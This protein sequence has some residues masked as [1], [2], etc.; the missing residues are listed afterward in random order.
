MTGHTWDN[1]QDLASMGPGMARDVD[2]AEKCESQTV[3]MTKADLIAVIADK[4]KFPWARAELLVDLVFG[5]LEQSMSRGEKIEVRATRPNY[6][7]TQSWMYLASAV[8][9]S[10][11]INSDGYR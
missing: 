11:F 9:V 3:S 4:L 8:M 10:T 7:Y 2:V 1:W 5:C 6:P